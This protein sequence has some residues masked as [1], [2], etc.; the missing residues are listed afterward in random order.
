[1]AVTHARVS[2]VPDS[3]DPDDIHTS[4]WNDDHVVSLAPGDV[5][6]DPAGTA[7]AAVSTHEAAADPHTGYQKESEK[8][9]ANGYAGLGSGG[10]LDA[11]QLPVIDGGGA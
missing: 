3:V 5:G 6:A 2:T 9:A 8:N 7:A 1:M 4:D 10:K 11:A